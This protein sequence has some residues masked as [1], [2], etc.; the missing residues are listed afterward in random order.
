MGNDTPLKRQ[1]ASATVILRVFVCLAACSWN[2]RA[3]EIWQRQ[4]SIPKEGKG[5]W[6]N[7]VVFACDGFMTCMLTRFE[8]GYDYVMD[9]PMPYPLLMWYP[10]LMKLE[11]GWARD[12]SHGPFS[13]TWLGAR[14]RR[15]TCARINIFLSLSL[16][17]SITI[18]T[19]TH[20][21]H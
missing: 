10:T 13:G 20:P 12:A 15:Q 1:F 4:G 6:N 7:T 17:S 11:P 9:Y 8:G 19:H 3:A 16:S 5:V 18:H 14:P 21:T 2:F